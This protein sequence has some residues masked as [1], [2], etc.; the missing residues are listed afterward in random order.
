MNFYITK[1]KLYKNPLGLQM[2][3]HKD[4]VIYIDQGWSIKDN[5]LSKG[6]TNNWC[7]ISLGQTIEISHN[8]LRD[9][10]LWYD[11]NSATTLTPLSNTVPADGYLKY[12]N[13]WTVSYRNMYHD[14]AAPDDVIDFVSRILVDNTKQF[15]A[16]NSLPLIVPNNHGVDTLLARGLLDFVGAN[17]MIQ[18]ISKKEYGPLQQQLELTHYGFNQVQEYDRP[19]AL[20]TGFYGDEFL[21]RNPYYLQ[22][23]GIDTAAEFDKTPHCYMRMFYDLVYRAKCANTPKQSVRKV[24]EMICNDQQVWHWNNTYIWTPFKDV[25][26]LNLLLCDKDLILPQMTNA[27]LSK[28]LIKRFNPD[29]LQLVDT[30]KNN[31]DP[32]WFWQ[33]SRGEQKKYVQ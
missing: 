22:S 2:F 9:F 1:D 26:L 6:T 4:L 29:Y 3:Q 7:S 17:Y 21:L 15:T 23:L 11:E 14:L 31:N 28:N 25:R 10:S 30:F 13:Q 12:D 27:E 19:T 24:S 33:K 32:D 5:I 20:V 8:D 18:D 16:N